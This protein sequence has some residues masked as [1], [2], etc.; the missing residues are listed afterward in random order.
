MNYQSRRYKLLLADE[1]YDSS[2]ND[3]FDS[4][5]F[6]G[7][8]SI[9]FSRGIKPLESFKN[10]GDEIFP[11]IINDI[12]ND[13]NVAFGCCVIQKLFVNGVARNVG[14][15][16]GLKVL[17]EYQRKI[18]ILPL[19]YNFLYDN[20][21]SKVDLFYTTILSENHKAQ[22]ILEKKRKSMPDYNYIGNYMVHCFKGKKKILN[23]KQGDVNGIDLFYSKHSCMNNFSPIT[24]KLHNLLDKDFFTMRD[25]NGNIV[26]ACAIWN[27][28]SYKKYILSDYHGIFKILRYLP[29]ELLGYPKF[30]EPKSYINYGTLS[31]FY[32]DKEYNDK[33]LDFL[34]T[35]SFLTP[36]SFVIY[37]IFENHPFYNHLKKLKSVTYSSKVY[38]VDW[39]EKFELDS[40]PIQLEVGLL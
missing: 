3:I 14:Y 2:I 31:F 20:L 5:S 28:Q 21:K 8:I 15:L 19:A 36:Y 23:V 9:R 13:K 34:N 24:R 12:Q 4:M 17:P 18:N 38:T 27:Q 29:T 16:T 22:K 37:G 26:M 11:L 1:S 6:P 33:I 7:N 25:Q 10:D 40:K 30:P 35:V 39:K 32:C